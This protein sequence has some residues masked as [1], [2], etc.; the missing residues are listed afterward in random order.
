VL[1]AGQRYRSMAS[2]GRNVTFDGTEMRIEAHVFDFKEDIYGEKITII[3]LDKIRDMVK[4]DG[5][6]ALMKQ[7]QSDE[8]ISLNWKKG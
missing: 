7:M 6:E 3:W 8:E 1:I 5:I 2:V 4:F